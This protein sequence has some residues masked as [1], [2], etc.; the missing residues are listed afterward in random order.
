MFPRSMSQSSHRKA[1]GHHEEEDRRPFMP[2]P[3]YV[4]DL[5]LSQVGCSLQDILSKVSRRKYLE[6]LPL[7]VLN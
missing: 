3:P 4:N 2:L 7:I 6:K 1:V 5:V